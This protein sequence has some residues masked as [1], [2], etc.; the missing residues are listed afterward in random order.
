IAPVMITPLVA[1]PRAPS[2]APRSG[3]SRN[4][5]PF[6][7]PTTAPITTLAPSARR[8][9]ATRRRVPARI[10]NTSGSWNVELLDSDGLVRLEEAPRV[11]DDLVDVRGRVLPGIDGDL[12]LRREGGHLH[13][14][15]V[16]MR[17]HVVRRH[18]QRRLDGAHEIA[19]H[20][21]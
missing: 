1:P 21:E 6:A 13:R 17:G 5:E 3:A 11:L 8:R 14:D 19:R 9:R 16:G 20:G 10:V 12:G 18:Q 2:M 15:L 7:P 4:P